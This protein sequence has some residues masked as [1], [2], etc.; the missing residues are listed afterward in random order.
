MVTI[1]KEANENYLAKIIQLKGLRKHDNAD[2]LQ[3]ISVDFQN[4]I[5]G[6]DAKDGDVYVFF[7]LECKISKEYLSFTNSFRKTELNQDPEQKGFF[8]DK[9][10]VKAMK[11]RGEKSMGYMV[12]LHTV[13]EWAG[14]SGMIAHIGEEFDTIN[15]KK[16]CEK[17]VIQTRNKGLSGGKQ[18]K[19]AGLSKIV[20]GQQN[21]HIST[22][23]LRKNVHMINP[24]DIISVTYKTHGTSWWVAN[25]LVKL[26]L[27]WFGKFLKF[28]GVNITDKDYD[29]LYGSRRVVKNKNFE[30]PKNKDHF[31]GYDLWKD[32]SDKVKE[33]IPEG[34]TLYGEALGY[35][36]NGGGIQG[37]YDYGCNPNDVN[38]FKLEVYRITHTTPSGLVTELTYPQIVD[39]CAGI[40]NVEPSHLFYYGPA[41]DMYDLNTEEHWHE[42]FLEKLQADYNEKDCFMCENKV[43]E[44][45]I[46]VRK[47]SLF[48]CDAYKLKSFKFLKQESDDLDSGK[49]DMESE[50]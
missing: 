20:D 45:G 31:Y 19:S 47:E 5:T 17:Y 25:V 7:P 11:L 8:E 4:V 6:M 43:P 35:D 23:N 41:K 33:N 42:N 49:I 13:E 22:S 37:Q 21:F 3:C 18:G 32:I 15:G 10:R 29:I 12:P 39:M 44:E 9:C 34:Y 1:S 2:R 26:N 28:I 14:I 27:S 30:D 16:I 46:V 48:S 24:D 50:N 36:R 38:T 40:D